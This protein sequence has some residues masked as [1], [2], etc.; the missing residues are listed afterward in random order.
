VGVLPPTTTP[1]YPA[2]LRGP[3]FPQGKD[4]QLVTLQTPPRSIAGLRGGAGF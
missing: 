2:I 4:F 3:S 1:I